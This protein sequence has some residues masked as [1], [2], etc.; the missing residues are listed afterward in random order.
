MREHVETADFQFS[1]QSESQKSE[2]KNAQ[3]IRCNDPNRTIEFSVYENLMYK[4]D[5]SPQ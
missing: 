5:N 4:C 1:D 2:R 3:V